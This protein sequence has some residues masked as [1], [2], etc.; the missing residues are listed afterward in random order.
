IDSVDVLVGDEAERVL[1]AFNDTAREVDEATLPE[2]FARLV[3]EQPDAV[4]VVDGGHEYTYRD[5]DAR[6]NRIARLLAA[7]SVGAESVVGIAVP[8]SVDQVAA[9]LGTLKVGAAYL[10]LDLAHPADRLAY[11]LSD[12][13]ATVVLT[14]EQAE[15]K[16]PAVPD[17][18]P[19]VLD[20]PRVAA[21]LATLDDRPIEP[22]VHQHPAAYVIYTSGS[23]GKPKGVVV[24]HEGIGSLIATAVD[25]MG[26]RRDAHVLQFASIG[27]DV[28]VFELCMALGYGGRLVLISDQARVAGPQL[29]DFLD[30]HAITHMILPPSLV[31]APPT[32]RELPAGA[33]CLVG[34]ETVPPELFARHPRTNLIAAY[35]LTEATVNS[36]LWHPEP[37]FTGPVPIGVPDPNTRCY[38][39]DSALR[40]VPPG[41]VGELYVG[42]RGLARGYLGRPGLTAERFVP[43]PFGAPGARMYRTGDR[44]R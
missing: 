41:V 29:T 24:S 33:T 16:L 26:L 37:G 30:E 42:G 10:P 6:A 28:A 11:M 1:E 21:E 14:T 40:P 35:G 4:A 44:A 18:L 27:F 3:A 20:E 23:T 13:S 34:T 22:R 43:D 38:V 25:R 15:G 17:V 5:L 12:S 7:R 9:I 19:V 39:L 32:E 2:L 8:R 31:S 36:T